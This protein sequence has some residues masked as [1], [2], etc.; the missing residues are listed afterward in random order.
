MATEF[1]VSSSRTES[2]SKAQRRSIAEVLEPLDRLAARSVNLIADHGVRFE[3]SGEGYEFPRYLFIGPKGGDE[4][5]RIGIFAGIHGDEPE[6]VHALVQFLMLLEQN[7]SLAT[8]YC[9]FAYPVCNATGFED[10]TRFSRSGRDLNREFWRNSAEPEVRLMQSELVSHSFDGIIAL[11]TDDTSPGFYGF[12]QGA[13]ITQNLL[14]PALGA[15]AQFLPV[16]YNEVIDGFQARRGIIRSGYDGMLTAPPK[17]RP[18]PFEIVLE[19]P[20]TAP[21][22]LKE[23]AFIASLQS[24]LSRYREF[25]AYAPN[26]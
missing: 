13:T 19:T 1:I 22:Y 7:P 5:I 11:H 2:A 17:V 6:G 23:A 20:Q 25:I 26:L 24:I 12:A 9:L 3:A 10:R 15:A 21:E 18:R 16:N 8:G 4:P 14:E